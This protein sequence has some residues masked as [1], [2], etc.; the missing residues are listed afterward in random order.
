MKKENSNGLSK[1]MLVGA[2]LAALAG[3]YFLNDSKEAKSRRK[4]MKGWMLRMKGDVMDKL[5]DVKD[6]SAESYENIV[7]T[8]SEKYAQMK[9]V[10]SKELG[11]LRDELKSHWEAIKEEIEGASDSVK[12][13]GKNVLAGTTDSKKNGSKK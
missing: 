10:D 2:G 11:N 4:E 9:D 1:T 8:I 5:E 13:A 7:D 6:M 12:K 3:Y